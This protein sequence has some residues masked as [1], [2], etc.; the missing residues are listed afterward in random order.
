M[1]EHIR[2]VDPGEL[3]ALEKVIKEE[4]SAD[5]ASVVICR[6][7]CVLLKSVKKNPPIKVDES[8]CVGCKSCMKIGCPA[9]SVVDKKVSIDATLCTGCGV[10]AQLCR[11]DAL[12]VKKEG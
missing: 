11:F 7:P 9:I 12:G 6:R 10:C 3:T 4:V 1:R 5:C 8:K 2:V